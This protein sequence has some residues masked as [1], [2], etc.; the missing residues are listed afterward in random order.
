[1]IVTDNYNKTTIV[2]EITRSC[3]P[4]GKTLLALQNHY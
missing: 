3:F 1:M 2:F 4:Y